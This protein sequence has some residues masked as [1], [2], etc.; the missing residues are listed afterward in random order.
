MLETPHVAIGMAIAKAVPNPLISIPLIFVSHLI[1]DTVPHWNP[2]L[3][4]ETKKYGHLTNKTFA[5]IEIDL[6]LATILTFYFAKSDSFLYI[7]A[8]IAMLPD[9]IEGP[10]Y[11]WGYKNKYLEIWRKFQKSIQTDADIFWGSLTQILVFLGA[12]YIIS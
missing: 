10:Y 7:A 11:F 4:T 5:I 6:A 8:F 1:L 3:N 12:L 9:L 2:H